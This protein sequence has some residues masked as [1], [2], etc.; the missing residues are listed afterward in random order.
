MS[1]EFITTTEYQR[2][3]L[4]VRRGEPLVEA[5]ARVV[6]TPKDSELENWGSPVTVAEI[7]A[8]AGT[9]SDPF[10]TTFH[11]STDEFLQFLESQP[12]LNDDT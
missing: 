1:T 6:W 12:S 11:G 5:R 2:T 9:V 4:L 3:R 8:A 7:E 10:G